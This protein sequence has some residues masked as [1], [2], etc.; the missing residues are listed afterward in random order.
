ML[1][2]LWQ[3]GDGQ[4]ARAAQSLGTATGLDRIGTVTVFE[5]AHTAGNYLLREMIYVVGRK[6]AVKLR[7]IAL[8]LAC[9]VPVLALLILPGVPG[10]AVAAIST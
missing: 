4:F 3:I 6:H 2:A 1:L 8:L 5:Q 9:V 7:A 10:G